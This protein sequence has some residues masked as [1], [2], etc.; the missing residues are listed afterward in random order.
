MA[1][2]QLSGLVQGLDTQSIISQLMAVERQPRTR[3]TG[4]QAQATKRQSL[5]QDINTKLTTLKTATDDLKSV[6]TW[7]DTQSVTSADE[8]KVTATRTAGA[9]P[10]GASI[11]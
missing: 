3:I 1:G 10:G 8:T 5:L 4:E 11:D 9:A 2:I 7:L 6:T